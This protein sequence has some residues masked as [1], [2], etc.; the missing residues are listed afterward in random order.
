MNDI[1]EKRDLIKQYTK[2]DLVSI[3][4]FLESSK[5]LPV[6][7]YMDSLGKL[8][9]LGEQWTFIYKF[10]KNHSKLKLKLFTK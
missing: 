6:D 5:G 8:K 1:E 9:T 3:G 7:Y 4:F 2:E 10:G